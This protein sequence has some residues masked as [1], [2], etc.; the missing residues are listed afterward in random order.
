MSTRMV[1]AREAVDRLCAGSLTAKMLREQVLAEIRRVVPFDAHAWL[2]TDPVTRVGT[3]PLADIPGLRWP[4]LPRFGRLR[5]LTRINRWTDMIAAGA[6]VGTLYRA[7]DGNLAAS[8]LWREAQAALGVTD[9]AALV[10]W[11]RFG[12]WAWLDLWRYRPARPF[13]SEEVGFLAMLTDSITAGLRRAQ[14]RTFSAVP[15]AESVGPAVLVL[16]PGL[17][18]RLQTSSAVETLLRLNPPDEPMS[19][20]PAAAY[21]VGAA[22]IA[23]EHGIPVGPPWSRVHLGAGRW[24]TLRA[25]RIS[26]TGAAPGYHREYRGEYS[27]PNARRCSRWRTG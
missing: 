10:F 16:G 22:L 26:P 1:L 11:D 14:A 23:D 24:V 2:L 6:P 21:N 4:D 8:A 15:P 7:T 27:P 17:D 13:T 12:C 19:A 5:Y 18:V 20:I 25:A 3:S 9:V